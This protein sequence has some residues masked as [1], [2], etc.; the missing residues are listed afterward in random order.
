MLYSTSRRLRSLT[1]L[2]TLTLL[3]AWVAA[4]ASA[5]Q[6]PAEVEGAGCGACDVCLGELEALDAEIAAA[7][8]ALPEDSRTV[9]TSHDA[10]GYFER[11]YGLEFVAPQG[12]STEAEA[13]ARD[14]A[15][16]ITQVRESGADAVFVET[17]TDERLMRRIA[18]ETGAEIGGT[19]YSDA[20][21][22]ADGPAPTYIEMMRH[23]IT[24]LSAA[25]GS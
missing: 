12:V 18:E 6:P 8:A 9:V 5:E 13:S 22:P 2:L 25:L 11:A 17:I 21:S 14:V 16:L 4:C 19:L 10:F 1:Y 24:T 7:V 3:V 15:M 23:N 20:L